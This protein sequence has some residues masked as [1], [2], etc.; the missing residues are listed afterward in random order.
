MVVAPEEQPDWVQE[1]V[2]LPY[3][4]DGAEVLQ[5]LLPGTFA[6]QSREAAETARR[7]SELLG[8]TAR[9]LVTQ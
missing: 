8:R 5:R 9:Q 4:Q 6:A 7:Q 1:A 2:V 3:V